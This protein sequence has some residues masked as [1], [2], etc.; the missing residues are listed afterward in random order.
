MS[1]Q[2]LLLTMTVLIITILLLIPFLDCVW[3]IK[4]P[5]PCPDVPTTSVMDL[6]DSI[7][8]QKI[9][10]GIPFT[11]DRFSHLFKDF[12][13]TIGYPFRVHFYSWNNNLTL[14]INL[15]EP[16]YDFHLHGDGILQNNTTYLLNTTIKISDGDIQ[17][18]SYINIQEP[19]RIWRDELLTTFY[20]CFEDGVDHDVAVL[21]MTGL[22]I[23]INLPLHLGSNG[24]KYLTPALLKAINRK[25]NFDKRVLKTPYNCPASKSVFTV[26][27]IALISVTV[28]AV[29]VVQVVNFIFKKSR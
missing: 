4:L 9:L 17:D 27:I 25:R 5:G 16:N 29:A 6:G 19:I 11:Q 28:L 10:L 24:A 23:Y 26:L 1:V 7:L 18:C 2:W 15:E 20:S 8:T 12:N 14:R 22:N 21:F 13:L 3:L